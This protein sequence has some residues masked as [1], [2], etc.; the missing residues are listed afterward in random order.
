MANKIE[1]R[2]KLKNTKTDTEYFIDK[3]DGVV[4]DMVETK[5]WKVEVAH[6]QFIFVYGRLI[7]MLR[8]V[9]EVE[10]KVFLCLCEYVDFGKCDLR[11]SKSIYESICVHLGFVEGTVRNAISALSKRH[12]LIKHPTLRG[13][14]RVNPEYAWKGKQSGRTDALRT[15][16]IEIRQQNPI[17]ADQNTQP[18]PN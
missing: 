18:Q 9:P 3:A 8:D 12:L 2:S 7:S 16:M 5:H 6:D 10:I 14:Y 17:T 1:F 4:E 15:L 11:M 13:H